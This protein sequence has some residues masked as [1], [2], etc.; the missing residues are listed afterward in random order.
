LREVLVHRITRRL[1]PSMVV[2]LLA[3]FF[4]MAGGAYAAKHYLLTSTKQNQPDG[5]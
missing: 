5:D 1:T 3:L 4:A 2:A